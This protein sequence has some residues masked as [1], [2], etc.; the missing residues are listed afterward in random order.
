MAT[1]P[2]PIEPAPVVPDASKAEA[3]FDI[4][5]EDFMEWLKTVMTP[6]INA[7][8]TNVH[9]N[10]LAAAE[11]AATA[12][13]AVGQAGLHATAAGTAAVAAADSATLSQ[14]WATSLTVV[15]GGLFGARYYAQQAEAAVSMLPAGSINDS[16]T[17]ADKAW[18]ST[19]TST[20]L[21][22]KVNKTGDTMT[23]KLGGTVVSMA[24][25]LDKTVTNATAT[26]AVTLDLASGSDF[27]I[28]LTGATTLSLTGIP[29]LTNESLAFVV[30]VKQGATAYGLTW[31]SG[32]TWLTTGGTAPDAPAA[33]KTTEYVFTTKSGSAFEGRKGAAT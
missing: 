24:N 2:N 13:A 11:D 3:D 17:A 16:I 6:G 12:Q 32:V 19:K 22:A 4:E 1:A 23:G 5:Y 27:D 28:T 20:E 26:G 31:F 33:N 29:A 8:A 14:N 15:S 10:A 30:R 9:G 21:A 7:L 18:S 25:F